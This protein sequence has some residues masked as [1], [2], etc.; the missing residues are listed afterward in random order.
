MSIAF[1][2]VLLAETNRAPFDLSEGERELVS[3][4]N[5]EYGGRG[6]VLLFL[7]EYA[8]IISLC[9]IFSTLIGRGGSII[10]IFVI[11]LILVLLIRAAWPR[12]RYD[13]LIIIIWVGLLPVLNA[14]ILIAIFV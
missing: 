10:L 9:I 13:M 1:I 5:I 8:Q 3:G 2:I 4:F 14:I 12:L 6:F 11:T 7:S